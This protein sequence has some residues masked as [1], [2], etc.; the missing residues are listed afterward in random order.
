M[1]NF[2]PEVYIKEV[3]SVGLCYSC[4]SWLYNGLIFKNLILE[5]FNLIFKKA[6]PKSL[7]FK[8]AE[9]L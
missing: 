8:E 7:L 5:N 2:K 3:E 1:D 6:L 4:V 9:S